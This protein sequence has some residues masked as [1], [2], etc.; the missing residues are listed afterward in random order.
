MDADIDKKSI[1]NPLRRNLKDSVFSNLF[2]EEWYASDLARELVPEI[3]EGTPVSVANA[4]GV[5]SPGPIHDLVLIAGDYAIMAVEAQSTKNPNMPI[6]IML[7]QAEVLIAMIRRYDLEL[8]SR[9]HAEI[10]RLLAFVVYTG[11]EEVPDVM[12]LSDSYPGKLPVDDGIEVTVKVVHAGNAPHGS[13]VR[14]YIMFCQMAD[15]CRTRAKGDMELYARLLKE[16]SEKAN[17]LQKYLKEKW[18]EVMGYYEEIFNQDAADRAMR[19]DAKE[20]G[21]EEG[22]AEGRI[23]ERTEIAIK[24]LADGVAPEKVSEMT[25]LS[26]EEVMRLKSTSN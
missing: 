26:V 22:L 7:Y 20:E 18:V 9:T 11:K 14:E 21:R 12:R 19:K 10:P 8:L 25:N 2:S 24:L 15:E 16:E 6:R 5:M 1:K 13:K 23:K 17:I 4:G 3:P